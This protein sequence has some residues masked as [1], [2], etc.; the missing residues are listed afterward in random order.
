[1][2]KELKCKDM[3]ENV[4]VGGL[5]TLLTYLFKIKTMIWLKEKFI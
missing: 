1:M 4:A 2:L 5:V 3:K